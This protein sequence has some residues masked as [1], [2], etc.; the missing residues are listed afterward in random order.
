MTDDRQKILN[1]IEFIAE[2]GTVDG[3]H[4]KQ[5]VVDQVMRI[6]AGE[7]YENFVADFREV[8]LDDWPVGIAP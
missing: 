4:H 3:A 2:W 1:A 5:W 7:S 8:H 6:L